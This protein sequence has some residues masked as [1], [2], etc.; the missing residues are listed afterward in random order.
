[1]DAPTSHDDR[2]AESAARWNS[3]LALRVRRWKRLRL[4]F[5]IL[6]AA[7]G[8]VAV[9]FN[10]TLAWTA[11]CSIAALIAYVLYLD[12]RDQLRE[13]KSRKW[14]SITPR[15]ASTGAGTQKDVTEK[16]A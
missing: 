16:S 10:A 14:K 5:A 11:P 7:A 15:I 3:N 9:F 2:S 4:T 12:S 6:F 8:I 1:M 13:V